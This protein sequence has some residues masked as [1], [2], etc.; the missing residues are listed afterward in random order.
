M[1][2][3]SCGVRKIILKTSELLGAIPTT[4][5]YELHLSISD[6]VEVRSV[7]PLLKRVAF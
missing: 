7:G 5:I 1:P 6:T 4:P 3:C 2:P